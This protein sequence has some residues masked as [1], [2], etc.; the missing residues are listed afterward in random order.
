MAEAISLV[1]EV[2]VAIAVAVGSYVAWKGL[3]AWKQQLKGRADHE[4][5]RRILVL[6]YKY[7]D[8]ID[9]GRNPAIWGH[10]MEVPEDAEPEK[11]DY[12]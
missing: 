4:L 2:V 8:A 3:G 10:E 5:A 9:G 11:M 7:R 1:S 12:N 6:L